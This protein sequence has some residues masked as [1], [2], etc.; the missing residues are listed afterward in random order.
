MEKQYYR[1]R[2]KAGA[3]PYDSH[4][5]I[6]DSH[7]IPLQGGNLVTKNQ[8]APRFLSVQAYR[9]LEKVLREPS[10]VVFAY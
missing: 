3:A 4:P 10:L 9:S 8:V 6:A 1:I 2:K 7:Y 5:L